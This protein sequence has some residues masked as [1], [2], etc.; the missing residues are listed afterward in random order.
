MNDSRSCRRYASLLLLRLLPVWLFLPTSGAWAAP[1]ITLEYA[2][3]AAVN[4]HPTIK[5]KLGELKAAVSDVEGAEWTRYPT[6]SVGTYRTD[7][8]ISQTS[9]KVEQPLWSGGRITGQIEAARSI[10]TEADVTVT[11]AQQTILIQTAAAYTELVRASE[12]LRVAEQNVAEHKRLFEMIERRVETKVSP[13]SDV[14]LAMAR[15]QAAR[16]EAIQY[17]NLAAAAKVMLEQLIAAAVEGVL[18]S[19]RQ[20]NMI[21]TLEFALDAALT[22]SPQ[23]KRLQ[24]QDEGAKAKLDVARSLIAPQVSLSY[25]RRMGELSIGQRGD[26]AM[27][28]VQFLPGAGLSAGSAISAASARRQ[29]IRD[30]VEA[31][32]RLLIQQVTLDW[33]DSLAFADQIPQVSALVAATQDVKQ[34]YVRQYA[35]GRKTWIDVLNAQREAMQAVTALIDIE[36]SLVLAR[37][38]LEILTGQLTVSKLANNL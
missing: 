35:V 7:A 8:G 17:R 4:T 37:V 13:T 29:A 15:L 32:K 36:T 31:A 9:L 23:L 18:P 38:R 16:N 20:N 5:S 12:K 34:S 10:A 1:M 26:Q 28:N 30:A 24:A 2:L 3:I 27:V 6:L 11:E 19:Q 14:T 22:Y 33:N 21:T 25:E